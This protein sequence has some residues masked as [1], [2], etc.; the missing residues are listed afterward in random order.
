M[1]WIGNP[2]QGDDG[3]VIDNGFHKI[4]LLSDCKTNSTK[5]SRLQ[6]TRELLGNKTDLWVLTLKGPTTKNPVG[7]P[8]TVLHLNNGL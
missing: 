3:E 1:F 2:G 4:I 7:D 8:L 5:C 6:T